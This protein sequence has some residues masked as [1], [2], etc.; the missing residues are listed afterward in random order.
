M[1]SILHLASS[2]SKVTYK[3]TASARPSVAND[4][5]IDQRPLSAFNME[6]ISAVGGMAL[7]Y[8]QRGRS[9][10]A[11]NLG[12][13]RMVVLSLDDLPRHFGERFVDLGDSDSFRGVAKMDP[14]YLL[15]E[16][17]KCLKNTIWQVFIKIDLLPIVF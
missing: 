5:R 9:S 13:A 11:S 2:H 17:F 8:S 7:A 10:F 4:R 15:R 14:N 1:L 12:H 3:W 6:I 16:V